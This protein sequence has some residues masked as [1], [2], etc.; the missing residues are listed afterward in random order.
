[1]TDWLGEL[2]AREQAIDA[3]DGRCCEANTCVEFS[4]PTCDEFANDMRKHAR[5]LIDA[6]RE[7]DKAF[8]LLRSL[9]GET[10]SGFTC[11]CCSREYS[12]GEVCPGP[13]CK[14]AALLKGE[15]R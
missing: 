14:L 3:K 13:N 5:K 11:V 1:M 4:C 2:D 7:R 10:K 15:R 12:S 9:R 8:S 6:A